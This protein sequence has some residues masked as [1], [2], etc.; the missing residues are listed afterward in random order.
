MNNNLLE[1]II[2]NKELLDSLILIDN[3]RMVTYL[4]KDIVV[5]SLVN[6][7]NKYEQLVNKNNILVIY[8]G[9]FN[10]TYSILNSITGTNNVILFPNYSYLG[11]NSFLVKNYNIINPN[12]TLIKD[13]NYNKYIHTNEVF[14][15]IYV[16]GDFNMFLNIKNDFNNIIWIKE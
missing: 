8:D 7:H 5:E 12:C 16:I 1:K 13:K 10:I 3:E 15:S 6:N 9:S 11:I 2:D 4:S 14:D